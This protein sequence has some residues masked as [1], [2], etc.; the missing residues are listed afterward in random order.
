MGRRSSRLYF[1]G[2]DHKEIYFQGKCH[3]AMYLG[4]E[5]L[6]CKLGVKINVQILG[7]LQFRHIAT[8]VGERAVYTSY[9]AKNGTDNKSFQ[10]IHYKKGKCV[11]EYTH[12]TR[13]V[14]GEAQWAG[15]FL[16]NPESYIMYCAQH[17][18]SSY[19]E[20][21]YSTDG[22]EFMYTG[23]S[24]A[25]WTNFLPSVSVI[26]NEGVAISG[27]IML[28][29]KNSVPAMSSSRTT[30]WGHILSAEMHN[31]GSLFNFWHYAYTHLGDAYAYLKFSTDPITDK[32]YAIRSDYQYQYE[33]IYSI[34]EISA[35]T[36]EW[37]AGTEK[38]KDLVEITE[39]KKYYTGFFGNSDGKEFNNIKA[40]NGKIFVQQSNPLVARYVIDA[41]S[42][43][44]KQIN[45]E[46]SVSNLWYI[47]E[48]R[49]Y[50]SLVSGGVVLSSN[51][52]TWKL[53]PFEDLLFVSFTAAYV[54]KDGIYVCG[55]REGDE[56][57]CTVYVEII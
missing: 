14:M 3:D 18:G 44:W 21:Y 55:K 20:L 16:A 42:G 39:H 23:S 54:K 43:E 28:I 36:Y 38:K 1:A 10:M 30:Y 51:G 6:W 27:K 46:I 48:K 15:A 8:A 7:Y 34:M 37:M 22:I 5:L 56:R 12:S 45:A 25:N 33:R 17:A 24:I 29:P 41:E 13:S 31:D 50:V 32:T 57:Y 2:K 53:H 52:F 26:S 19:M 11:G 49:I 35:S 40:L 9:N 47:K 4:K